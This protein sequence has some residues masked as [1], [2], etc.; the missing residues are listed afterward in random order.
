MVHPTLIKAAIGG[1]IIARIDN[2]L[3][4]NELKIQI[5]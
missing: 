4:K 3:N 5:I 1:K 2:K